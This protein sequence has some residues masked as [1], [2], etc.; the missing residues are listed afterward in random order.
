MS[1][2]RGGGA[3]GGAPGGGPGV[4]IVVVSH[5]RALATA[6]VALAT[7][8]LHGQQP[9]IAVAGGLGERKLGGDGVQIAAAI[10]QVDGERGVVVLM[11]LGSAVL[12]AEMALDLL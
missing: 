12:S 5:S 8:M 7:E 6:A 4:G 2:P 3:R 1:S 9:R 11:D 10:E